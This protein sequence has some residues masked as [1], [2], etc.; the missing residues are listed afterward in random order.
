M[1]ADVSVG[2]NRSDLANL[3]LLL[4]L[5]IG[6][7]VGPGVEEVTVANLGAH[8]ITPSGMCLVLCSSSSTVGIAQSCVQ[9]GGADTRAAPRDILPPGYR[10][11]GRGARVLTDGVVEDASTGAIAFAQ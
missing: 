4:L 7:G 6:N 9:D 5:A 3:L 8:G 1:A 10:M 2:E 11:R